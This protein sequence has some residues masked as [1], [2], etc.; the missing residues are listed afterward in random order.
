MQAQS[1][2]SRQTLALLR[3]DFRCVATRTLEHVLG[4][5]AVRWTLRV[6]F[7]TSR[8]RTACSQNIEVLNYTTQRFIYPCT[9]FFCCRQPLS[10]GMMASSKGQVSC[11]R[12]AFSL[13]G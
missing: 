3:S 7:P 5:G 6:S 8:Q 2:C 4:S 1:G 12:S 13:P 11:L 9:K 10:W